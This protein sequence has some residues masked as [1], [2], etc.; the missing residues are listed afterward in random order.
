MVERGGMLDTRT[1]SDWFF[2]M[3]LTNRLHEDALEKC[4]RARLVIQTIQTGLGDFIELPAITFYEG[5]IEYL[6]EEGQYKMSLR[7]YGDM[8]Y[9]E[10]KGP[11]GDYQNITMGS[12]LDETFFSLIS[13]FLLPLPPI[14]DF[15]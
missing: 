1:E 6:W 11:E 8:K 3:Y 4:E 14:K 15:N 10:F 7:D 2:E 9:W 13:E 12:Q 5:F